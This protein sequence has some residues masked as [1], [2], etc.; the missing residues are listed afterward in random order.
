M[1]SP[2]HLTAHHDLARV[3]VVMASSSSTPP[4]LPEGHEPGMSFASSSST[5]PGAQP[6]KLRSN[7]EECL[8]HPW[9]R[10]IDPVTALMKHV[11][12]WGKRSQRGAAQQQQPKGPALPPAPRVAG[13]HC[14]PQV[15]VVGAGNMGLR[16]VGELLRRGARRV[17]VYDSA[18]AMH[19]GVWH[20]L[21]DMLKEQVRGKLLLRHDPAD[22]LARLYVAPSLEA[23]VQGASLIIEA[24]SETIEAKRG[25]FDSIGRI[26]SGGTLDEVGERRAPVPPES[27]IIASN[28]ACMSLSNAASGLPD[29]YLPRAVSVRFMFP[30]FFCD[31]VELRPKSPER[32]AC[33]HPPVP[34]QPTATSEL[35]AMCA[36]PA[37]PHTA[38]NTLSRAQARAHAHAP[39]LLGVWLLSFPA[40]PSAS[41]QATPP[42]LL[43]GPSPRP[44][45]ITA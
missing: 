7:F 45:L 27:V 29:A 19:N 13:E 40:K 4:P 25:F 41:S 18:P 38:T 17:A 24:V 26:L 14:G 35:A 28:S 30:V 9:E 33:T 36:R 15:A 43:R 16:I 11:T 8:L 31:L 39:P 34:G 37:P 5:I 44:R 3:H 10:S 6:H 21:F 32:L 23:C 22:M 12:K 1:I 42:F 20:R 2:I